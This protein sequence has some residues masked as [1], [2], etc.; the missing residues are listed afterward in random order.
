MA[1]DARLAEEKAQLRK[2]CLAARDGAS[3][4][5]RAAA[6]A[7]LYARLMGLRGKTIAGYLPIGSEAD[8]RATMRTLSRDNEI[9]VP[10]VTA[11]GAPLRFRQ[12]TPGCALEEGPFRVPVPVEGG[13]RVPD[14]LIVP[15]VGFDGD[16]GRLGYGG[17]F[18]DRTLAGLGDVLIVGLAVEAQRLPRI[19]REPTDIVLPWIVTERGVF[20]AATKG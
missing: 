12:W 9:C 19:P 5:A 4:V 11:K 6:G 16:G 18:Y 10:V 15:L 20:G 2:R 14:V 17:G 1:P 3:D 7:R 8:P 13:W